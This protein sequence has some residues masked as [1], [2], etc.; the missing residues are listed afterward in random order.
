MFV[1]C[2]VV[3]VRYIFTVGTMFK[4]IYVY[5]ILL[6][7]NLIAQDGLHTVSSNVKCQQIY[8]ALTE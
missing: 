5:V 3:F 2:V 6:C 4:Y 8:K 7:T 1:F